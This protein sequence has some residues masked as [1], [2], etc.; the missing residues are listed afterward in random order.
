[1]AEKGVTYQIICPYCSCEYEWN[2]GTGQ[3]MEVLHCDKCGRELWTTERES[4]YL[5]IKCDCGGSF[6]KEVP[7]ICPNC[8]LELNNPRNSIT[9]AMTWN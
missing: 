8:G 1:M 7:I 6:D 2:D 9:E 4:E 5:N 3:R